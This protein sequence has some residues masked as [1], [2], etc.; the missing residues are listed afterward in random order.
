MFD[1]DNKQHRKEL[2]NLLVQNG[3]FAS[4]LNSGGGIMHV[5]VPLI[6]TY[7]DP[8]I[9][10]TLDANLLK[11]VQAYLDTCEFDAELYIATSSAATNCDVGFIGDDGNG[12]QIVSPTWEHAETIEASLT[13]FKRLWLARDGWIRKLFLIQE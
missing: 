9:I 6:S 11:K 13:I 4:E 12:N 5:V 10:E 1:N 2:I 8:P 3:I 7:S